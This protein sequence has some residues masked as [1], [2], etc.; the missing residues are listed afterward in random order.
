[1]L[2]NSEQK[3]QES[4]MLLDSNW[5]LCYCNG[6]NAQCG[7]TVK[8]TTTTIGAFGGLEGVEGGGGLEG[9]EGVEGLEGLE[10]F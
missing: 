9:L 7:V 3:Q 8:L 4:S 10:G 1:M 2:L 6:Q 5:S